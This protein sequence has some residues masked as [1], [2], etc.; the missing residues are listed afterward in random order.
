M[1]GTDGFLKFLDHH[2]GLQGAGEDHESSITFAFEAVVGPINGWVD[3]PLV[4]RIR[5]FNC[6]SPSFVKGVR[7]IMRPGDLLGLQ[8]KAVCLISLASDQWFNSPVPIMEPEEMSEFCEHLAVFMVDSGSHDMGIRKDVVT[9]LFGM[10]RS[11]EWRKHIVTRLWG[12]LAYC[13]LVEEER[14]S[15]RWCLRNAIEL[16]EF[17][18]QL[19]DGEGLKWW[20]VTLWFHYDKLSTTVRDRAERIAGDMSLGDGFVD[21]GLYLNLIRREVRRIRRELDHWLD[22]S[23]V[24]SSESDMV[25]S[26]SDTVSSESD[27][28]LSESDLESSESGMESRDRLIVVPP[29][30]SLSLNPTRIQTPY[31]S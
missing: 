23:G 26:E 19:P 3:P 29:H 8:D 27:V 16:L 31:Y 6:A 22:G 13:G 21:L 14:E 4:E 7:S 18:R 20:Y 2:L 10:L 12:V 11:S 28:D 1:G 25:W 15:F 17:M 9:I 5:N 30:Y 24:G